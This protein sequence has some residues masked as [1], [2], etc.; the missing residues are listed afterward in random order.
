MI[1]GKIFRYARKYPKNLDKS[2]IPKEKD[3]LPNYFFYT[4]TPGAKLALLDSGINPIGYVSSPDGKRIPA[5]LISS[6]PHKIGSRDTPWQDFFDPDNGHIHYYGD[7]KNPKGDPDKTEGNKALKEQFILQNSSLLKDREQACPIIFFKRVAVGKRSKGNVKFQGFGIIT[8][9]QLVTQ[10]NLEKNL[11]FSNY[12]FD[13]V[14]FDQSK[15]HEVFNWE[16]INFRRKGSLSN[17]E[18]LE[19]A[20]AS[21]KTWV[22]NGSSKIEPNRRR[23]VKL[24]TYSTKDQ[25]PKKLSPEEKVLNK[26]YKFYSGR[27]TR[28][29]ALAAFVTKLVINS[30]GHSYKEGWITPSASDG[31]AD[32][33]GRLDVGSDLASAKIIVLGQAKCEDP[34]KTTNGMHIARTVARLRRGWIGAYVTTSYFSEPVQREVLEDKYPIILINGDRIAKELLEVMYKDGFSNIE[35]VL[36]SIDD[37]YDA[38]VMARDPEEILYE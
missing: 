6:S 2:S 32:F 37:S 10:L 29:E 23:V 11:P 36:K 21:W 38:N 25:R 34:T 20:P 18:T 19:L 30:N 13:F 27:K 31:G 26:I 9:I 16:W 14:I 7:N 1:I 24:L 4:H 35:D 3:G 17:A 22:K 33:I 12:S 28:F 15:E 8:R 5:I